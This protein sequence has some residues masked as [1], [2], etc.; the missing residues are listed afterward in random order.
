MNFAMTKLVRDVRFKPKGYLRPLRSVKC[1]EAS[2]VGLFM[3][4]GVDEHL[5][6]MDE[7]QIETLRGTGVWT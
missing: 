7:S 5:Q 6:A 1:Q 4:V 3:P 2:G